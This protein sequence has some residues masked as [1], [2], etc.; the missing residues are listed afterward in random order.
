MATVI[1]TDSTSDITAEHIKE[2]GVYVL[3][4]I[5]NFGEKTYRDTVDINTRQFF[6]MLSNFPKELN[7]ADYVH[8]ALNILAEYDALY[9]NNLYQTLL[10]YLQSGCNVKL[11]AA[12][13]FIHRNSMT[14]RLNKIISLT[15]LDLE[16]T[17][18]VFLLN[19]SFYINH[20]LSTIKK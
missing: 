15:N 20:Y 7:L 18:V 12:K 11:A 13:L 4:V 5:V 2:L 19:L 17:N 14:Y 1:M 9:N 3:P 10:V 8:P 16:N 6:D